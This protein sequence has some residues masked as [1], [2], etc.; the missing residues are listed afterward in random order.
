MTPCSALACR[1]P[2]MPPPGWG[3]RQHRKLGCA[4]VRHPPP[5]AVGE[6]WGQVVVVAMGLVFCPGKGKNLR[7][8]SVPNH[9]FVAV[10]NP[11]EG[12]HLSEGLVTVPPLIAPCPWKEVNICYHMSQ[13]SAS[14][15]PSAAVPGER[16]ACPCPRTPG[17]PP[18][19]QINQ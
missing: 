7:G 17:V 4:P 2:G 11:S 1:I 10:P 9:P 16:A 15:G 12:Q 13:S 18:R 8:G 3:R 5:L 6:P 14:V 19:G